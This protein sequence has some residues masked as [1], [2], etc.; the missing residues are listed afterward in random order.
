MVLVN[1]CSALDV[2]PWKAERI[3]LLLNG[4]PILIQCAY[5]SFFWNKNIGDEEEEE[6]NEFQT[7]FEVG[8]WKKKL[9]AYK[10]E[11]IIKCTQHFSTFAESQIIYS[12]MSAH[13]NFF[14]VFFRFF[15]CLFCWSRIYANTAVQSYREQHKDKNKVDFNN[16]RAP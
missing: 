15:V 16:Q 2:D 13:H 9:F 4:K 14:F 3:L 8:R 5:P 12:Y 7:T 10:L 11:P 1:W 6:K